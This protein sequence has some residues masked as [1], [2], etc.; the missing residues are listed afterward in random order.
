M[1]TQTVRLIDV[2]VLG[3]YLIFLGNKQEKLTPFQRNILVLTGAATIVYNG[4][5]YLRIAKD[6]DN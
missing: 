4:V 2:F 1:K 5:N 3:P 6:G